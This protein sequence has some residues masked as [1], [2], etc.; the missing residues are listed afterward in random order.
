MGESAR[1]GAQWLSSALLSNKW[2]A[3]HVTIRLF[4]VF[5]ISVVTMAPRVQLLDKF[6][7]TQKILAY[8]KDENFNL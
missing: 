6:S 5:D 8:V 1:D 3:K 4:E 2:E 7:L